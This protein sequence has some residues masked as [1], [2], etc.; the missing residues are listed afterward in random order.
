MFVGHISACGEFIGIAKGDLM[1][2]E[3][4]MRSIVEEEYTNVSKIYQWGRPKSSWLHCCG[5]WI[6]V[7]W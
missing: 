4:C 1:P 2:N 5:V 6:R 3:D 7:W